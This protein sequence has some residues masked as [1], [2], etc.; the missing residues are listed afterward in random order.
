MNRILLVLALLPVFGFTQSYAPAPGQPGSTAISKDSNVIIAWGTG[1]EVV[2]GALDIADLPLGNASHGLDQYALGSAEGD[3]VTVV[4]LGDRGSATITFS[5]PIMN[6]PGPDFAVFENGFADN[7]M[8][9]AFVEVSSDGQNFARFPSY[10]ETPTI[11]QIDNFMFG[12]CRFVHNLAGK[13]RQGYGTPF[14][15]D[16][17][18]P[19]IPIDLNAITHVRLVDVVGSIDPTYGS[20]DSNGNLI[21]DPYPTAFESG[22]FDLDAVGVIH[23]APLGLSDLSNSISVYPNPAKGSVFI[24]LSEP[25]ELTVLSAD[26]RLLKYFGQFGGGKL[27]LDGIL[28]TVFLKIEGDKISALKRIVVQ[29]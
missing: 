10:S 4:S 7:Y 25:C 14:D 3:G 27:P 15:L 2:R 1:V 28:G 13:Y 24:S 11:A 21:N 8:E 6:G 20:E 17:L 18:N 5:S 26:G 9:F 16:E 23:Q 29:E 12:D 22:G 19:G